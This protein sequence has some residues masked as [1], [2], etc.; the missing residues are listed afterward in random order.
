V[1]LPPVCTVLDPPSTMPRFTSELSHESLHD[2]LDAQVP[3]ATAAV[4]QS[5][6]AIPAQL[7]MH[8]PSP[9]LQ[10]TK[11]VKNAL[12]AVTVVP[13]EDAQLVSTQVAQVESSAVGFMQRGKVLAPAPLGSVLAG[14]VS[15]V[16]GGVSPEAGGW[17]MPLGGVSTLDGGGPEALDDVPPVPPHAPATRAVR[18]SAT[19]RGRMS[20]VV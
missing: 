10:A 15:F 17:S 13:S 19:T 5:L 14:G 12:H 11:Q 1:L 20:E 7:P 4:T 3:S 16:E 8:V 18:P 2:E 6:V 9:H